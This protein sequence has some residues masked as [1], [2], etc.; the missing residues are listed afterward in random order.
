MIGVRGI[1][2]SLAMFHWLGVPFSVHLP[3]IIVVSV[4][5]INV[6][7]AIFHWLGVFSVPTYQVL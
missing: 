2:V 4:R 7:L 3:G 6:S 1:N 5:G